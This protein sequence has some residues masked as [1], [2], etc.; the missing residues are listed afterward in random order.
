LR[1]ICG[2]STRIHDR[3]DELLYNIRVSMAQAEKKS[4]LP[5]SEKVRP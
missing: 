3:I 4:A 5:A 2:T 1:E